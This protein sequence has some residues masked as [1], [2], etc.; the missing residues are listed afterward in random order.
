MLPGSYQ[1]P[2]ALTIACLLV[3]ACSK[4][5]EA[6]TSAATRA[7]PDYDVMAVEP[8]ATT[9]YIDVPASV[10]GQQNVE[11]R[12]MIDGYVEKIFVDEGAWVKH[13][14][15]L[16]KIKAPQYE[17][18]VRTTEAGIKTA[19]AA[20]SSARMSVDKVRP[21]VEREIISEYE[22]AE[23][24]FSLQAREAELAQARAALANARTNLGYTTVSSPADGVIGTLPFKV[25]SL[26]SASMAQPLTTVSNIEQVHAYF[27]VNEKIMLSMTHGVD[28]ATFQERIA[29]IPQVLFILADGRTYEHKGRVQAASGL[30]S[31]ETGSTKFRATFPNPKGIL[32]SGASGLVRIPRTIDA[33]LLVPQSATY[34]LQGK[35]FAYVV[36]ADD[37][38]RPREISVR[39]TPDG[40]FFVA[41]QG[42]APGDRVVLE[43]VASLK[44]GAHITP[45]PANMEW[46][47]K[48][49]R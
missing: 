29:K 23:A 17:Q 45:V 49:D 19:E 3:A 35:R 22:L 8:R 6:S 46:E 48:A 4:Q 1:W 39:A 26:V 9:L 47:A 30:I 31:Q 27:S 24:R 14:Q 10:M 15:Q 25:G 16:F 40:R 12:P 44:S 2:L 20:V 41:D 5:Q 21:L 7:P 43:G 33:A 38:V 42:L 36:Q 13:G 37:T 32:R 11:I 28:G 18:A 34:E